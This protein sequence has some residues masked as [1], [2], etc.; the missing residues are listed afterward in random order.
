MGAISS[1]QIWFGYSKLIYFFYVGPRIFW[2]PS[3]V[4]IS[5]SITHI[6]NYNL[7]L[8]RV[9]AHCYAQCLGFIAYQPFNF[10]L[11]FGIFGNL[12]LTFGSRRCYFAAA[13]KE[14]RSATKYLWLYGPDLNLQP[15]YY[16]ADVLPT[17]LSRLGYH[18]CWHKKYQHL[19]LSSEW[20]TQDEIK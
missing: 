13:A 15:P 18:I 1:V 19:V 12:I 8:L 7:S 3:M 14:T 17:E 4:Y 2:P 6:T 10:Q 9:H 5:V 11:I 20:V 16:Q